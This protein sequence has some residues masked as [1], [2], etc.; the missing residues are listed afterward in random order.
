MMRVNI[1]SDNTSDK[2]S[3]DSGNNGIDSV[4]IKV[5]VIDFLWVAKK[6]K[7]IE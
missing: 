3:Y 2:R 1:E 7:K 5:N 4:K 6:V